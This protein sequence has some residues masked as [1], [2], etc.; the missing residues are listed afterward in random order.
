MVSLIQKAFSTLN[1]I[2]RPRKTDVKL[3]LSASWMTKA[4]DRILEYIY[5]EGRTQPKMI[6][7]DPIVEFEGGYV[8]QRLAAL[9]KAGFINRVGHGLYTITDQGEDY[10]S[11][12][13]D[14]R[15]LEEPE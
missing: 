6:K 12:D 11:G 3:R 10:L 9:R 7:E 5:A 8:D 4:D 1:R 15:D 13:F 2:R 14:A